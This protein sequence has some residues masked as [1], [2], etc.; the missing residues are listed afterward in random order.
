MGFF[1]FMKKRFRKSNCQ[2][3]KEGSLGRSTKKHDHESKS[4]VTGDAD[5]SVAVSKA[6]SKGS[7]SI[8]PPTESPEGRKEHGSKKHQE[9]QIKAAKALIK[10]YGVPHLTAEQFAKIWVS[11]DEKRY[12]F[13]DGLAFTPADMV[14]MLK[15][16]RESFPDFHMICQTIEVVG[17][18]CVSIEKAHCLGTHTGVPYSPGPGFPSIDTTGLAVKNDEERFFL[19]LD[20]NGKIE[21][22]KCTA[23]ATKLDP[24][25][26]TSRL[27]VTRS[28]SRSEPRKRAKKMVA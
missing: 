9:L 24:S 3:K 8:R 2:E 21:T 6:G 12:V 4:S 19:E 7:Y 25:D 27:A 20:D 1:G 18:N 22:C 13:E 16:T 23:W 5:S 17:T 15:F 10:C 26:S 28:P 11:G 14:G